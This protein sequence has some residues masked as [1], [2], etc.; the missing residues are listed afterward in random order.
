MHSGWV[1]G[2]EDC[3]LTPPL[4]LLWGSS[5]DSEQYFFEILDFSFVVVYRITDS[6]RNV[7]LCKLEIWI[8][9]FCL[10]TV[11]TMVL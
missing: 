8:R 5:A 6:G 11:I 7:G 3:L 9:T 2:D 4:P 10:S 1:L